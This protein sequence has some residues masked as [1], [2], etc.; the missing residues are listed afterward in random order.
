MAHVPASSAVAG[1]ALQK[2]LSNFGFKYEPDA[3]YFSS[4]LYP[5]DEDVCGASYSV[6]LSPEGCEPEEGA[7][8]EKRTLVE[9]PTPWNECKET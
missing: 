6:C 3:K 2:L 1:R 4:E 8:A 7:E 5:T 9:G